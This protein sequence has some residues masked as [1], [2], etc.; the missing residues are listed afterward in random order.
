MYIHVYLLKFLFSL[1]LLLYYLSLPEIYSSLKSSVRHACIHK[2]NCR[3]SHPV[4]SFTFC[5]FLSQVKFSHIS[6]MLLF[7]VWSTSGMPWIDVPRSTRH[8]SFLPVPSYKP[9]W[10]QSAFP[11][12][13]CTLS[14]RSQRPPFVTKVSLVFY[15]N[16]P[17]FYIKNFQQRFYLTISSVQ[18]LSH[19]WLFATPGITACQA[20]LSI[21][22]SQS[23]P[24]LMSIES[25]MASS[26]LILCHPLLLPQIPPSIR[27][28]SNESTL[29]MRWPKFW[30]F[31]FSISPSNE[32]P[33]R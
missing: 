17:L 25:V 15:E 13:G 16:S 8:W 9:N 18:S 6:L 22:N 32:H 33:G 2:P 7:I 28:F 10:G 5:F 24:K 31:S 29:R 4:A 1:S 20:S 11:T 19:V 23:S 12:L 21:T 3:C 30:S 14:Y 26:H 27:V